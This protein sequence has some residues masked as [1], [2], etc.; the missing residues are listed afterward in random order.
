MMNHLYRLGFCLLLSLPLFGQ[1]SLYTRRILKTLTSSTYNGR[2]Y[3]KNGD[4]KAAEFI[5]REFQA[6]G[7]QL[8]GANGFQRFTMPVNTF[9]GK[10]EVV[11][12]GKKLRPGIDYLVNAGCSGGKGTCSIQRFSR[13]TSETA[14]ELPEDHVVLLDTGGTSEKDVL[15]MFKENDRHPAAVLL[16]RDKKLTW[17]VSTFVNYPF[18]VIEIL[19]SAIP[20]HPTTIYFAIDQQF[21]AEHF[22]QNV[23]G[24][25]PGSVYPDSFLVV[26]AHYD[27]LGRMGKKTYFPGANDNASGTSMLLNMAKYYCQPE[28]RP[29]YTMVFIAFAGEEAGL[30]GSAQFTEHPLINLNKINF[31]LNLDLLGTGDEGIMVV[32]GEILPEAFTTL[33]SL[34]TAHQFV[35][36]VGKRGKARNSDHYFFS[37]KGVPAFFIYTLGGVTWYH[38]ILDREATLPLTK[39]REVFTL[40]TTFLSTR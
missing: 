38:D 27:H 5:R 37:E 18:P 17:T 19:R 25:I 21:F 30:L 6:A 2:G 16:I 12:N 40:L 15:S 9:P 34:N 14:L 20:A 8:Q 33:D 36:K 22:T 3:V 31:L 11:L 10:M 7:L 23:I 35:T 1:D 24:S 26:T 28:H 4:K 32:N 39:Y 13:F 29:K